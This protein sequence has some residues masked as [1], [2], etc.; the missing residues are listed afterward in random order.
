MSIHARIQRRVGVFIALSTD[1]T[2]LNFCRNFFIVVQSKMWIKAVFQSR[3]KLPASPVIP[4]HPRI[5]AGRLSDIRNDARSHARRTAMHARGTPPGVGHEREDADG[6]AY[7]PL[8]VK[9]A[10]RTCGPSDAEYAYWPKISASEVARHSTLTDGWVI[11]FD[12][13]FDITT[14]AVTHPGFHN[15]GQ[16][17]VCAVPSSMRATSH[18]R[19]CIR[20]ALSRVWE[21]VFVCFLPRRGG[22]I[23][24]GGFFFFF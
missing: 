10:K 2:K 22:A 4:S 7:E 5:T 24:R 1:C 12:R 8:S 23:S 19:V 6:Y 15:A 14:F 18:A 17:R 21:R 9:D 11:I 16:S 13:V 20:L 3:K